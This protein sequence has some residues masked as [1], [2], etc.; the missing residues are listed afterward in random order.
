MINRYYIAFLH[1]I[2]LMIQCKKRNYTILYSN[3]L[4]Y[5]IYILICISLI[6]SFIIELSLTS[7]FNVLYATRMND[8]NIT[9]ISAPP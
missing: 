6:C 5:Y 2:K 1:K 8:L 9:W 3:D 7:K 4:L